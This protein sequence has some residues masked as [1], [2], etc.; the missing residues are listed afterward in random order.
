MSTACAYKTPAR[1]GGPR[2][3]IRV[4][5]Q[6]GRLTVT[7]PTD[8]RKNGYMVWVCRCDCGGEI[9]LDTRCLQRGTVT[10]CGCRTR[11]RPGQRDITGMRFGLLTAIEPT[12][13]TS[14]GSVV[15]RCGC[16]CGG[17]VCAPLH[18]LTAG[19]RKSCGCLGRPPRKD[20]IGKRFGRL[21]VTAYAGKRAGMHRWRCLC[22]CGNETVVGQTLLQT[23]KTKSCGCLQAEIHRDNLKLVEGTS[24]TMLEAR[25]GKLCAANSSGYTGVYWDWRR[26]LWVAQIGFRGKNYYLG[27]YADQQEAVR[28][29]RRGEEMY[30]VFLEWYYSDRQKFEP[31]L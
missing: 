14:N 10:D 19:Y 22:D 23:G 25:R 1:R 24:V 26:G 29:R 20:Y 21:T 27:S 4:G 30:D 17:Q 5:W 13:Q 2:P 11:V 12:G 15:W 8:Q 7:A 9:R 3:Q 28:A 16:D 6:V 31:P 18:Q